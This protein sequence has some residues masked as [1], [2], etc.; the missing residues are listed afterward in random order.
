MLT[1][2][3]FCQWRYNLG[4]VSR[5]EKKLSGLLGDQIKCPETKPKEKVPMVDVLDQFDPP[6]H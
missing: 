1:R 3:L 2:G 4:C 5:L 6:Q